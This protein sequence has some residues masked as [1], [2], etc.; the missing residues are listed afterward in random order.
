MGDLSRAAYKSAA[1]FLLIIILYIF[2]HGIVAL[3]IAPIQAIYF[4]EITVFA[5]FLYLPHGIRV[6]AALFYGWPSVIAL[7]AGNIIAACVFSTDPQNLLLDGL[8]FATAFAASLTG[9]L[10]FE[11][12]RLFGM[13]L[14]AGR[15]TPINWK[16]ILVVGAI[17][18][19]INSVFQS[20]LLSGVII[21]GDGL[22][23]F[24]AVFIGDIL[25]VAVLMFV[26][27]LGFRWYRMR[28]EA[29]KLS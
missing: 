9:V 27:M 12:M 8:V 24:F 28:E 13:N 22:L 15:G 17:S 23:V 2:A 5:C 3:V 1:P 10:A 21:P 16:L 29:S 20:L 6:L 14:Y 19:V 7:F 11:F 25:G 26:L 4:P 18:S